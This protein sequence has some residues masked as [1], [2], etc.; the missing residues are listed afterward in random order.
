MPALFSSISSIPSPT[1]NLAPKHLRKMVPLRKAL[2]SSSSFAPSSSPSPSSSP[3]LPSS[4]ATA[5]AGSNVVRDKVAA[6][7]AGYHTTWTSSVPV[8]VRSSSTHHMH[9]T[10][11]R[12]AIID[13]AASK[14]F[15]SCGVEAAME[16]FWA[17]NN[18]ARD[19]KAAQHRQF[20][21]RPRYRFVPAPSPSFPSPSPNVTAL[22][23]A[24]G[25]RAKVAALFAKYQVTRVS[26]I[27]TP[28]RSSSRRV[29]N[30]NEG[31]AVIDLATT[32]KPSKSWGVKAAMDKFWAAANSARD[33]EAAQCREFLNRPRCRFFP[34]GKHAP[35]LHT[36]K[37]EPTPT[38]PPLRAKRLGK[39]VDDTPIP[40]C[41]FPKPKA[42]VGCLKKKDSQPRVERM[43]VSFVRGDVDRRKTVEKWIG[44]KQGVESPE[45][46]V[47]DVTGL[48]F[49]GKSLH[50][51]PKPCRIMGTHLVGWS[52]TGP[53]K[54]D[55]Y[56][57]LFG[58]GLRDH[59]HTGCKNPGCN[60]PP[61]RTS[62]PCV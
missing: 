20:L 11:E 43:G 39:A 31:S 58:R 8:P 60:R 52:S 47:C 27:P 3:P 32:P 18:A 46:L 62:R 53:D 34:V 26:R 45:Q 44:I 29:H 10:T 16:Q 57:H 22:A 1:A 2:V 30:A 50:V 13:L 36:P 51:H 12:S 7:L 23:G 21:N 42:L 9:S 6:L 24:N 55:P 5:L 56:C 38:P 40:I 49:I 35:Q 19:K 14:P 28:V 41:F 48:H 59:A 54:E 17:A 4:N 33:K 25:A 61:N 37:F 15:K